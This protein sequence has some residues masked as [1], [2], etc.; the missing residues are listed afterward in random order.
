MLTLLLKYIS[1][2]GDR[3]T[4]EN[5]LRKIVDARDV[6]D[7]LLLAYE[8]PEASGRYICSSYTIKVSD[9]INMLKNLYP[10]YPYPKK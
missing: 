8:K 3:D 10:T 1:S 5:K 6:A 4:V 7:A 9:M 2:A